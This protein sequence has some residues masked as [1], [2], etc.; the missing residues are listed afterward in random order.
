LDFARMMAP[1]LTVADIADWDISPLPVGMLTTDA[2]VTDAM[3]GEGDAIALVGLFASYPGADRSQPVV[4]FGHIALMPYEPIKIKMD[5]A[6]NAAH[7]PR[8]AYLVEAASWGGQSG[9]PVFIY[10]GPDRM[11]WMRAGEFSARPEQSANPGVGFGLLGLM[12]GHVRRMV[13]ID[14]DDAGGSASKGK[15]DLNLGI[16]IVIP[17]EEILDLLNG[18]VFVAQRRWGAEQ[19]QSQMTGRQPDG[20]S[21]L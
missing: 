19:I 1:P 20:G 14:I 3:V 21:A 13:S 12:H 5:P 15:V 17:A 9:S 4:R 6:P 18:D 11:P 7:V 16:S 10:F 2:R 8:R